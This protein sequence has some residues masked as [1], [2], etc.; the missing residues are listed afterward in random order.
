MNAVQIA[1][2]E[3][4][5]VQERKNILMRSNP[6][7]YGVIDEWT[8]EGIVYSEPTAKGIKALGKDISILD[9]RQTAVLSRTT[10]AVGDWVRFKTGR[11]D[12]INTIHEDGDIQV[13]EKGSFYLFHGGGCS[14]SGLGGELI[15]NINF[16]ATEEYKYGECWIFSG[17]ESGA[18]R[19]VG[20][21]VKFKVWGEI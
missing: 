7:M 5:T 15:E 21:V 3:N 18:G 17:N 8:P 13:G 19:G 10:P 11:I 9:Q 2:K 4:Y 6:E 20:N 16:K 12:R 1:V 14:Y